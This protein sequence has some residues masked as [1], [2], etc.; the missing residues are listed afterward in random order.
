MGKQCYTLYIP[1]KRTV[2]VRGGGTYEQDRDD[3]NY[4]EGNP[5]GTVKVENYFDRTGNHYFDAEGNELFL[6][7]VK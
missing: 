2:H 3:I 7:E 5:K 1:E 4:W 6:K